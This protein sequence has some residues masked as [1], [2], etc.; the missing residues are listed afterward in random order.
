MTAIWHRAYQSATRDPCGIVL[1]SMISPRRHDSEGS[2]LGVVLWTTQRALIIWVELWICSWLTAEKHHC[3]WALVYTSCVRFLTAGPDEQG[4]EARFVVDRDATPHPLWQSYSLGGGQCLLA[5]WYIHI[6]KNVR[7]IPMQGCVGKTLC[8]YLH[9]CRRF[10]PKRLTV[11]SGYTFCLVS[12]CV[13]W[14]SNPQPLR[15]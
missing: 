2:V 9:L 7:V 3:T 8:V 15:C 6:R 14:E 10:Y 1:G 4:R 13:P 11:H 5:P 12:M